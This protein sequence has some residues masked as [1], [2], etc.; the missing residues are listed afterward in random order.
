MEEKENLTP[1]QILDRICCVSSWLILTS[2]A[3]LGILRHCSDVSLPGS[4]GTVVLPVLTAAAVGY[5]TNWFAILLLF[6]PYRPVKWLFGF[7]GV[8]PKKKSDLAQSLSEEIPKTLLSSETLAL[9]IQKTVRDYM[10][11]PGQSELIRDNVSAWFKRNRTTLREQFRTAFSAMAESAIETILTAD[12]CRKLY[13]ER[14]AELIGK[15]IVGNKAFRAAVLGLLKDNSSRISRSAADSLKQ[16]VP[17]VPESWIDS[18][19]P[20]MKRQIEE[21]ADSD[22]ADRIL[23]E[24]LADFRKWAESYMRS[25]K[26]DSDVA[27]LRSRM[28]DHAVGELREYLFEKLEDMLEND[29]FWTFVNEKAVP[30]V[31]Y[32]ALRLIRQYKQEIVNS[33][34]LSQRIENAVND[35]DAKDIHKLVNRVSGEHLVML[36][37][38]GFLLGGI[39]GFLLVFAQ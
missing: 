31:L 39:A 37:L 11:K 16:N 34:N 15:N 20:Y 19:R 2:V 27:D 17:L 7:Q 36:Q 38:L 13:R 1:L 25:P 29:A 28:R 24:K 5:L 32:Y 21:F 14:G 8:V 33:L 10:R 26:F 22:N 12:R 4:L 18:L 30:G 3:V 9:Q 6:R 23:K 35:Q